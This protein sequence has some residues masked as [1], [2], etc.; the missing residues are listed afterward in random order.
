M[1]PAADA[2]GAPRGADQDMSRPPRERIIEAL[3][4]LAAEQKW[5]EIGVNEIASRAGVSLPEFL[6][7][8]PS[9]GAVLGGFARMIDMK[10]L[11]SH[12]ASEDDLGGEPPRERLFDIIMNRL[13]HMGPYRDGLRGVYAGVRQEPLTIVALN[14]AA[15]NSWRFMLA[16]AGINTEGP[17]GAL[18]IQGAAVLFARVV[19]TWLDDDDPGQART[20]AKLDRE[21]ERGARALSL[22]DDAWKVTAPLRRLACAVLDRGS[23][24]RSQRKPRQAD[25]DGADAAPE[26][27]AG[28]EAQTQA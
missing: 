25:A 28:G 10:V 6:A 13:D 27:R 15:Q 9:K 3:M 5:S 17:M 16:A 1:S 12:A 11:A 14:K 18:R 24:R 21:L 26:A 20:L 23:G 19:E 8:F 7:A 2:T 22:A 4:A